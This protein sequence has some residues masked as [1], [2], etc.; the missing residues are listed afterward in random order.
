MS[1]T[2][3]QLDFMIF[4]NI[5]FIS[6]FIFLKIILDCQ[7]ITVSSHILLT[8]LIQLITVLSTY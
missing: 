7:K 6:I 4:F 1:G 8:M 5:K 2:L 3:W